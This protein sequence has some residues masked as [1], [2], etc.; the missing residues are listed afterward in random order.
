M[1]SYVPIIAYMEEREI[2]FG[3]EFSLGIDLS[4]QTVLLIRKS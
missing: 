1:D 2:Y 4:V 3:R